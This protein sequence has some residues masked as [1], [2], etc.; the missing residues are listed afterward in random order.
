MREFFKIYSILLA[1]A[2]LV[3][4][5]SACTQETLPEQEGEHT[6]ILRL[7]GGVIPFD[8]STKASGT[9][10]PSEENRLY[11]RMEGATG[12]VLGVAKYSASTNAWSFTYN[13]TLGGATQGKA[14]AVL[15]EK[16]IENESIHHLTLRYNTPIYE[17]ATAS[18]SVTGDGLTL[19]A[20]LAPKNGRIS[21]THDLAEG[22]TRYY[23][24]IIGI[25]YY[26]TFDLSDFSFSTADLASYPN[27]FW[28]EAGEKGYIY[29]L[30]T[31]VADPQIMFIQD[32]YYYCRHMPVTA[33]QPGQSG[34]VSNPTV[35][36]TGWR[37]Y[38]CNINIWFSN[39]GRYIYM[40]FV[41]GGTFRMGNDKDET[42][43][44]AHDVT[45]THYYMSQHEMTQ[46]LWYAVMGEPS[47]WSGN[48]FAVKDRTYDQIQTFISELNAHSEVNGKYRFRLPTEAE[49]E[50]AARGGIFSQGYTY[51][52]GNNLNDVAI[53]ST[54]GQTNVGQKLAN[55]LD[56]FD[57][58]G[59]VAE[60]CSD[61]YGKYSENAQ[62]R[63]TGPVSGDYR[64]IR[65]G[66]SLDPEEYFS[67]WHRSSTEEY[68]MPNSAVGFRLVMEVPVI[69][70]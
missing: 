58:S 5:A 13:G 63:P 33:F 6:C 36:M 70:K 12:S 41:P 23:E 16:N 54:Y 60:L 50:F 32:G 44:P 61:W 1:S 15:I 37:R 51:S 26:S 27:S 46:T 21:F 22:S 49:W 34:Y 69:E 17:D 24:R 9:F 43:M 62:I 65:G 55:E 3:F 64:V 57:M 47:E 11:V 66:A 25:S 35:D 56:L 48:H 7:D 59:N 42:A 14:H 20:T 28:L 8:G 29:G 40:R 38:A 31:D 67:V 19:S 53:W 52:G 18:F 10:S 4:V 2:L 39:V 68:P 30:F 45:L